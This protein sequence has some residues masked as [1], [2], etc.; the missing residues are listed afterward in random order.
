MSFHHGVKVVE[1]T[2]GIRPLRTIS[3]AVI[4][5]IATAD[6]A[7]ADVFPLNVPVQFTDMTAALAAAGTTGTLRDALRAIDSQVRTIV[8]VIR[9]E[10]GADQAEADAN[11]AGGVD[12]NGVR[13]GAQALLDAESRLGIRPRIL[14]APGLDT[15]PVANA[16]VEVAQ[17]LNAFVYARAIGEANADVVAYRA[18]FGQREIMLIANDVVS[19][20]ADGEQSNLSPIAFA[21]G[22]RAKIDTETGWHKALSNV[23]INGVLG[24]SRPISFDLQSMATDA[25]ELNLAD[26]TAVVNRDGFRFWGN[27]TCSDEPLFAFE[28]A[29]RTAQVLRDTIAEG[30][31]W[32]VD[33]PLRP[34]LVKD[35]VSTINHKL[36]QL[37]V[38]GMIIGGEARFDPDKNPPA[39]LA[40]GRLKIDYDFT[41]VP[42]AESIALTQR[43]T[44]TYFADFAQLA[45]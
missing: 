29:V 7:D 41:P 17:K 45:A 15:L 16:L 40:A 26:V 6:D 20:D 44:D 30:L 32:A 14:G 31:M 33:K 39:E 22:L 12:V 25:G 11:A 19:L 35:I 10:E 13:S 42:P 4:G 34:A 5:L 21:M 9:V 18:N 28:T 24:L 27:R 43:I 3:T 8:Q 37:R 2:E 23:A 36:S 1:V 38:A